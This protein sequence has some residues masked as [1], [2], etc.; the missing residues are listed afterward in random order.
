MRWGCGSER[1]KLRRVPEAKARLLF[2]IDAIDVAHQ[3]GLVSSICWAA[4]HVAR[5]RTVCAAGRRERISGFP[6]ILDLLVIP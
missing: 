2:Y 4:N 6:R 5:V 3:N 1:G